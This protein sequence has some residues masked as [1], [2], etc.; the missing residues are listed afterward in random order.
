MTD[1]NGWGVLRDGSI[2]P[3]TIR[4]CDRVEAD[5]LRVM[6]GLSS[7]PLVPVTVRF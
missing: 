1:I 5:R 3:W 2:I 4:F 6:W 7:F